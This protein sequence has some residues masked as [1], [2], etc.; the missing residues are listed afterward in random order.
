MTLELLEKIMN[1]IIGK[2][3]E[4]MG[5][6]FLVVLV[7]IIVSSIRTKTIIPNIKE[8]LETAFGYLAFII[9]AN[10]IDRLAIDNLFGWTGS[11][12]FMVCLFIVAREIRKIYSWLTERFGFTIPIL[13]S[14]LSQMEQGETNPNMLWQDPSMDLDRR[15]EHLRNELDVLEAKRPVAPAA[16]NQETYHDDY[17]QY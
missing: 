5:W 8:G 7:N 11:T 9:L 12:Q 2:P 15:I 6:A 16:P 13:D 4:V 14:R 1:F 17:P 10:I 3:H